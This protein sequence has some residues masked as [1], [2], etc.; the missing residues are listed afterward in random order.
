MTTKLDTNLLEE[1]T[2]S[3]G[4]CIGTLEL[5]HAVTVDESAKRALE[6]CLSV[7]ATSYEHLCR[8]DAMVFAS[9]EPEKP[10][11]PLVMGQPADPDPACLHLDMTPIT[12]MGGPPQYL[13]PDCNDVIEGPGE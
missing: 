10:A 6:A 2:T 8:V 4:G 13:C 9:P 1:L 12:T 5:A 7:I 11:G 3:L